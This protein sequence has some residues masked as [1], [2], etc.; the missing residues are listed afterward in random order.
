MSSKL[1]NTM[2]VEYVYSEKV[3]VFYSQDAGTGEFRLTTSYFPYIR[4][5]KWARKVL[6][7][8][9]LQKKEAFNFIPIAFKV[10]DK[11]EEEY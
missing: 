11:G 6:H 10:F 8:P 9:K 7:S 3:I 4:D 5:E 2:E 1:T